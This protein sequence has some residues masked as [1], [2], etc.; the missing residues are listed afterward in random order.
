LHYLARRF[1]AP[2]LV[3]GVE[4]AADGSVAVHVNNDLLKPFTGR[5]CWRVTRVDGTLVREGAESVT[6]A[7]NSALLLTTLRLDDL[8]AR[9]GARDVIVWLTMLDAE[10]AAVSWN[11]VTFCRPKHIELRPPKIK[12]DIRVWDDNSY[13]VSLTAKAPVLWLW[14]SLKGA[15]AKVD[16]NFICLEPDR[17]MRIRV[18]PAARMKLEDF[19][20]ALEIRSIWDTYQEPCCALPAP[21]ESPAPVNRVALLARCVAARQPPRKSAARTARKKK[22]R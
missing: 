20:R 9:Y 14:A 16:D 1:F 22:T 10:D 2:L 8:I 5:V 17:P 3:S 12:V 21:V 13:A 15:E 11:L 19:R 18:T 4:N 7:A 6:A